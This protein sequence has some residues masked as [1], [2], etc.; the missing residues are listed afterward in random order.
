MLTSTPTTSRA[1]NVVESLSQL[2]LPK[3]NLPTFSG[4]YD[5][6]FPF[7]DTF[8]SIIHVNESLDDIQK[9]QYLRASL[10]GDA[11]DIVNSLEISAVNYEVAWNLLKNRYD[12]KR[13]IAQNH[14]R[15]IMELPS[16]TRENAC[17]LRQIADGASKHIHALQAL[18]RP[19]SYWDD[20]LI[21]ILSKKLDAI[22]MREW[23]N[24]LTSTEL[25]TFKQ[26]LDFVTHRSQ[27]LE[28][29]GK[30]SPS[31]TRTDLRSSSNLKRKS[32]CVASVKLKC[33]H[34]S[35]EHSIYYC[36][37]FL[38]L[39]IPQRIAEIRKAKICL[40]CLRSSTHAANKCTAGNCKTCK[41]KHNTLLHLNASD[42]QSQGDDGRA[43]KT[44]TSANSAST[45]VVTHSSDS[46]DRE[47]VLLATALVQAYDAEGTCKPCRILLDCGSQANFVSRAFL[48]SLKIKTQ[49]SNI[50]I[51]GVN[52][53]VTRS[54]EIARI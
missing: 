42:T 28:S 21:Y 51:S 46:R 50:T 22:S 30:S 2:R 47:Y 34:C 25:P 41:M 4:Q 54:S 44:A 17:E 38:A 48:E 13:V 18:K 53:T 16:M 49:F 1:S 10:A 11:K 26:F 6:W 29:T 24:S 7:F 45:T 8:H 9:F 43:N 19:T 37:K 14:I 32:A 35:E 5:E 20:L 36:P 33:I 12:N 15:T 40:N 31:T 39:A 27:M 52:N 23:Q 3:L